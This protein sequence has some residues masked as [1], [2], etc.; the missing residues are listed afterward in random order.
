MQPPDAAPASRTLT[1]GALYALVWS[2]PMP[3]AARTLG[4]SP[5]G[6][7]KICDR[8]LI[9]C[10]PRGHWAKAAADRPDAEPLPA[11]AGLE[12]TVT[13]AAAR[14]ASRRPRTRLGLEARRTQ[15][16]DIAAAVVAGE[17]VAAASMKRIARD[18]G[19]SESLAFTYFGSRAA[20]LAD[21]ARR[22]LAAMEGVRLAEAG[23]GRSGR[24]RVALSTAAYLGQIEARGSVLHA[25]LA[26][27]E[28]RALLR[29]ERR[30][31]QRS[32]GQRTASGLTRRYG[33][34]ADIAYAAT[35]ALTAATRRAGHL[36]A[37]K[38]VSR[39]AAERL[40]M[41]MVERGNR[42]LLTG[43]G[44]PPEG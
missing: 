32:G 14:S 20:L 3:A 33:V 35:Q 7:A 13:I 10:P 24:S 16:L 28:V 2:R 5:T 30:A 27:P 11:V 40:V 21:L 19:V 22:E 31:A 37:M 1:R 25:L 4:L 41:A 34:E 17:G 42:D 23:R 39:E 15:M 29:P 36:L 38:R 43:G 26:A 9:P 12:Q 8:L 44:D 18:A 6:L